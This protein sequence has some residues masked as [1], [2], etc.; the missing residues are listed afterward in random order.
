MTEIEFL[1]EQLRFQRTAFDAMIAE[2]NQ[3]L[4]VG[5]WRCDWSVGFAQQNRILLDLFQ[6]I[7]ELR[8]ANA[9]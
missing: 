1:I 8:A 5:G 7:E 4:I 9:S 2:A 6:R 3:E